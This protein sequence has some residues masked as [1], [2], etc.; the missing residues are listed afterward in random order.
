METQIWTRGNDMSKRKKYRKQ[1]HGETCSYLKHRG[2]SINIRI[3]MG[4]FCEYN[5][6]C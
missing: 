1:K 3:N 2:L 6:Q 4:M 5:H